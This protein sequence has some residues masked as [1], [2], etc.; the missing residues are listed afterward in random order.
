MISLTYSGPSDRCNCVTTKLRQKPPAKAF[1]KARFC[2]KQCEE[3][4]SGCPKRECS[5]APLRLIRISSPTR[6]LLYSPGP[7]ENAKYAVL[8]YCWGGPQ[9]CETRQGNFAERSSSGMPVNDLS[10]TLREA[11]ETCSKL[12]F[13]YLWAGCLV[14]FL[15]RHILTPTLTQFL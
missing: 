13:Q 15:P 3:N 14:E 10:K 8:S 1:E 2:M 11:V 4:H 5:F 9:Q 12:G 6:V 7:E